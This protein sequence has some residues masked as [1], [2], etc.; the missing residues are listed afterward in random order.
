MAGLVCAALVFCWQWLTV[1]SNY[2]GSWTALFCTGAE[3]HQPPELAGE[4]I[5]LFAD[6][7]GYDG[8]MYHFVAHDPFFVRGFDAYLDAPRSGTSGRRSLGYRQKDKYA[9]RPA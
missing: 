9:R 4:H 5:Y 3:L 2:Q 6:S 1:H 7:Q 8:Q